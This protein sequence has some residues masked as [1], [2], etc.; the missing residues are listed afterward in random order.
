MSPWM[1]L[2]GALLIFKHARHQTTQKSRYARAL[3]RFID[4]RKSYDTI[5]DEQFESPIVLLCCIYTLG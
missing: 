4:T 3:N 1:N 2:L 5:D